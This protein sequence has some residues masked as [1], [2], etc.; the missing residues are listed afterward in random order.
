MQLTLLH[1]GLVLHE[2][3]VYDSEHDHRHSCVSFGNLHGRA[4]HPFDFVISFFGAV[5][6]N[7]AKTLG[8]RKP[9]GQIKLLKGQVE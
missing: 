8:V 7:V 1:G 5:F 6:L 2:E 4:L 3:G 9:R